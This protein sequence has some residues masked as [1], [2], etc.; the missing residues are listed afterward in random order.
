G[1]QWAGADEVAIDI[2]QRGG[3]NHYDLN[4]LGHVR[5]GASDYIE[6]SGKEIGGLHDKEAESE[7]TRVHIQSRL[8][9]SDTWH[10]DQKSVV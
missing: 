6:K 5:Q 8:D 10:R 9:E 7:S 3:G 2:T 4:G 1:L